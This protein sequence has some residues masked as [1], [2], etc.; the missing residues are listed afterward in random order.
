MKGTVRLAIPAGFE[1]ATIRVVNLG[2]KQISVNSV[3]YENIAPDACADAALPV[4]ARGVLTVRAD[5]PVGVDLL[6]RSQNR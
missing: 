5:G 2:A 3:A 6:R 4:P 1:V